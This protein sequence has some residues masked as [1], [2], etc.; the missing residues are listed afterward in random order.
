VVFRHT[1]NTLDNVKNFTLI[2]YDLFIK[3]NQNRLVVPTCYCKPH[4]RERV[5][6]MLRVHI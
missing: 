2:V 4:E 6:S 3:N 1:D 5:S